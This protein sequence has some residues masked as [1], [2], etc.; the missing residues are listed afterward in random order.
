MESKTRTERTKMEISHRET[1]Q[2][3]KE[4]LLGNISELD[5]KYGPPIFKVDEELF[6]TIYMI[7]N[8]SK[9]YVCKV[10]VLEAP[11]YNQRRLYKV[12]VI[13]VSDR[14]IGSQPTPL[15][16]SIL[17]RNISKRETELSRELP[18]FMEPKKWILFNP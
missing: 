12:K 11:K 4:K 3:R 16:A 7:E 14:A 15:Q 9:F 13:A 17:G 5:K 6:T 2:P 18:S 10:K 1:V 8:K